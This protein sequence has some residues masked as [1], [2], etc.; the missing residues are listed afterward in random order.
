MA[1][2]TSLKKKEIEII[3]DNFDFKEINSFK[4][5]EGGLE[6]TNYLINS[7]EARYV[8]TVCEQKT[9]KK[10]KELAFLLEYLDKNKFKTSKIIKTKNNES[11]ILFNEKIIMIKEYIEGKNEK[12]FS[13]NILKLIGEQL[14][15]LHKI[16]APDYLPKQINYGK[17]QFVKIKKY[18]N[19][20]EFHIWLNSKLEYLRP[21]FSLNLPK[22]LIHSDVFHDNVIISNDNRSVTIM[23]FEES[24]YY[25]RI[26][27]IGMT[28]IGVCRERKT[29]NLN[30][31]KNLLIGYNNQIKL[32][33]NEFDS[34]KAFTVYAGTSMTFW[35]HYNFNYT[36]PNPQLS[37]HYL[38]LKDLTDYI[39]KLSEE[40]FNNFKTKL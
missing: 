17:E 34:L 32:L 36:K 27:D 20:S 4:N 37:N 23:D 14:G 24:A 5:L 40:I 39:E 6:N 8:L 15:K 12:D 25:Y 22:S 16:E 19:N 7:D 31:V 1:Y 35:R 26:Y 3:T 33:D 18:A 11:V 2:Y 21:Y 38:E 30:K 29:I 10:A 28:I 9:F 13:A